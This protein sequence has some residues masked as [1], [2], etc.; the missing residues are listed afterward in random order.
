M[1]ELNACFGRFQLLRWNE[2]EKKRIYHYDTLYNSLKD[3]RSVKV[4]P[5]VEGCGSPFVFPIR[6][7]SNDIDHIQRSIIQEGVEIR[8]LMGGGI[9]DQPGWATVPHDGLRSCKTISESSFFVGIH[10]TLKTPNVDIV[11]SILRSKLSNL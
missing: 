4:W 8:S 6:I 10:Q 5:R 9:H 2:D 11:A 1:S 3:V 7:L